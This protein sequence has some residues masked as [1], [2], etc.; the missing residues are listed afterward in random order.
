[1]SGIDQA[2]FARVEFLMQRE[3]ILEQQI[4]AKQEELEVVQSELEE[5]NYGGNLFND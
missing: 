2:V 3:K 1:M 4:E 5:L